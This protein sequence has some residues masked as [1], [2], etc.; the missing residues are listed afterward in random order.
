MS[1]IDR[2]LGFVDNRFSDGR[3]KLQA[4]L[5]YNKVQKTQRCIGVFYRDQNIPSETIALGR[6][7]QIGLYS[8]PIQIAILHI[9][10]D[11]ARTIA[12]NVLEYVNTIRPIGLRLIPASAPIYAGIN[13]QQGQHVY[14]IDY[15]MQGDQ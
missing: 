13:D 8:Q 12:Y 15:T 1:S 5:D 2:V 6:F 3:Y 9:K 10:K 11:S 7:T 14:T 4:Y